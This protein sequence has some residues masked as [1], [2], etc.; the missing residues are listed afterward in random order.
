M[1]HKI[2][3]IDCRCHF[4]PQSY[5][6]CEGHHNQQ[7]FISVEELFE[8]GTMFVA[9]IIQTFHFTAFR[10]SQ[11]YINSNIRAYQ[12]RK[13][14]TVCKQEPKQGKNDWIGMEI[15]LKEGQSD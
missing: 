1:R 3:E 11:V 2:V 6:D 15:Y 7:H 10:T 13:R 5:K 4:S 8:N 12:P 9:G 14:E